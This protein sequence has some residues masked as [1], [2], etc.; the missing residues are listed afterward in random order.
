MI[1]TVKRFHE[2]RSFRLDLILYLDEI[3]RRASKEFGFEGGPRTFHGDLAEEMFLWDKHIWHQDR[4][5]S[6]LKRYVNGRACLDEITNENYCYMEILRPSGAF[7]SQTDANAEAL[8]RALEDTL[9]DVLLRPELFG[10]FTKRK[11]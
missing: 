9:L 1:Y 10:H 7:L 5:V 8:S 6:D 2:G 11:I 4:L 3:A